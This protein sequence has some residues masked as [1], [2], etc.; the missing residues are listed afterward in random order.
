L[1]GAQHGKTIRE[2]GN[3]T[4]PTCGFTIMV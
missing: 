3:P 1:Q 4:S 2:A